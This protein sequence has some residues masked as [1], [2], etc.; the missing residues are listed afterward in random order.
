MHYLRTRTHSADNLLNT[1]QPVSCHPA[2]VTPCRP[3]DRSD[4]LWLDRQGWPWLL[5]KAACRVYHFWQS[6]CLLSSRCRAAAGKWPYWCGLGCLRI[7]RDW[8][9][10]T[11]GSTNFQLWTSRTRSSA[12]VLRGT[13]YGTVPAGPT[14]DWTSTA[15]QAVHKIALIILMPLWDEIWIGDGW[16][17]VI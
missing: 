11:R 6:F 10:S 2:Q 7:D 5:S 9:H 15:K 17:F 16:L 1:P 13:Q 8:N 12:T 4:H 14:R 3:R